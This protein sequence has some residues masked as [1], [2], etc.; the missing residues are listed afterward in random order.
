MAMPDCRERLCAWE[1]QVR[2]L[3]SGVASSAGYLWLC[4]W[5]VPSGAGVADDEADSLCIGNT[6]F[7]VIRSKCNTYE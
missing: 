5:D 3:R 6:R 1:R 7:G 2:G 4:G